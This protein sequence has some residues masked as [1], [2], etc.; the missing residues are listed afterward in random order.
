[1]YELA[2][3]GGFAAAHSLRGYEGNCERLHGHNYRVRAMWESDRLNELG[4]VMD[5]R[6]AK[7]ALKDITEQL[8]HRYLNDL[9]AFK[10]DN[11]SSET[12]ARVIYEGLEARAP[13]GVSLAGVT[14]WESEGSSATY[15]P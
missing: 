2:I 6:D 8:D 14:V 1:M 12:L 11:P 4:L 13:E 9:D 5:F 10:V 3:E 15:R 7:R